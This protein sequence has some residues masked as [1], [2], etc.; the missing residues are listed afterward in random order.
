M[1]LLQEDTIDKLIA[2]EVSFSADPS[3]TEAR[4]AIE[5]SFGSA[6]D[7]LNKLHYLMFEQDLFTSVAKSLDFEYE[8]NL[9]LDKLEAPKNGLSTAQR[10]SLDQ[11][12]RLPDQ[13]VANRKATDTTSRDLEASKEDC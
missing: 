7:F 11:A 1:K 9:I 5:T 2:G 12:T 4:D 13:F 10:A 6:E 8:I 3:T